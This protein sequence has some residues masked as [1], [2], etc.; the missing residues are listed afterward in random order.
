MSIMVP[1]LENVSA[2]TKSRNS[3]R[4]LIRG[5]TRGVVRKTLQ[6]LQIIR[7]IDDREAT[8]ATLLT[9][10]PLLLRNTRN[11][12]DDRAFSRVMDRLQALLDMTA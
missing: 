5:K 2:P 8:R 10:T 11:S 1:S 12:A 6:K 7:N 4:K 3:R 9:Y